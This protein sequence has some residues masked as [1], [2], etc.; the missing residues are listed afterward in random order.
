MKEV[1]FY[2]IEVYP[3]FWCICFIDTNDEKYYFTSDS[4]NLSKLHEL[5][6]TTCLVGFNNYEYDD[7]IVQ[8]I[9]KGYDNTTLIYK[10]SNEIM[11]GEKYWSELDSF[12]LYKNCGTRNTALKRLI[13]ELGG[14][15]Q[16]TPI[17]FDKPHLTEEDKRLIIEYC[18]NDV[19]GTKEA[20][21]KVRNTQG[22][23]LSETYKTKQSLSEQYGINK[24]WGNNSLIKRVFNGFSTRWQRV[25]VRFQ[26]KVK[27]MR[28]KV[29]YKK[30]PQSIGSLDITYDDGG[31]H[32]TNR[33]Y[34]GKLVKDV[35]CFDYDSMYPYIMII[36]DLFEGETPK[37]VNLIEERFRLKK[38]GDPR[39]ANNKLIINAISGLL[40]YIE[41]NIYD[42]I[43]ALSMRVTGQQLVML[44]TE[45]IMSYGFEVLQINTDGVYFIG[46]M[47]EEI[48]QEIQDY[49]V[50]VTTISVSY[51]HYDKFIQK[52]VN[53]YVAKQGDKI[54]VKGVFLKNYHGT[55]LL[56]KTMPQIVDIM[57]A[58][59]LIDNV[60]FSTTLK[61]FIDNN[62][63]LPFTRTLYCGHKFDRTIDDKLNSHQRCNRIVATKEGMT[64]LSKYQ[65]ATNRSIVFQ[66]LPPH[67]KIINDDLSNYSV[68]DI[69]ID[70]NYYLREAQDRYDQFLRLN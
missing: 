25:R 54:T 70:F 44:L 29:D 31:I 38:L 40:G 4:Q 42:P 51:D 6:K 33:D 16:E 24:N 18:F 66:K 20:F 28:F 41:S 45:K 47:S 19:Y 68:N 46:D 13:S 53:N 50:E 34:L 65:N 32:G 1:T 10:L 12:D 61:R 69:D 62:D 49:I 7:I 64:S 8:N 23:L 39:Q 67:F 21:Y 9:M 56:T 52:D 57:L 5:V 17:P 3:T 36:L 2:D 59:K 63:L 15:V 60:E 11:M 30:P 26:D 55:S 27:D 37:L 22:V 14:N 48:K 43:K 35:H 58:D